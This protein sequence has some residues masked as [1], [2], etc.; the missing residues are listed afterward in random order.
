MPLAMQQC[1][2]RQRGLSLTPWL[3]PGGVR[4]SGSRIVSTASRGGGQ[5]VDYSACFAFFRHFR[6]FSA[7]PEHERMLQ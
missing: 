6:H 7:L 2:V 1:V 4:P 5:T 3:Q